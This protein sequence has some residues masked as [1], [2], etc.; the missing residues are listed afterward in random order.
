M[1]LLGMVIVLGAVLGLVYYIAQDM[2]Y[3]TGGEGERANIEA[4]KAADDITHKINNVGED[5]QRKIE[6]ASE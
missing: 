4:L 6:R 5:M 2:G 1:K 3:I